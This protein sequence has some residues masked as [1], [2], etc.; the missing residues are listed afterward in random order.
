MPYRQTIEF[1]PY[2]SFS[3]DDWAKLRAD[4]PMT[5]VERDRLSVRGCVAAMLCRTQTWTRMP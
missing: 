5:L 3:R 1:S 2:R 4:T